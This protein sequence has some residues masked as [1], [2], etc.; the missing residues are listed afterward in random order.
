MAEYAGKCERRVQK[1][2]WLNGWSGK[3]YYYKEGFDT[4]RGK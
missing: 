2:G 4:D 1:R 3:K